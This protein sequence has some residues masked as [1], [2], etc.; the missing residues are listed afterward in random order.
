SAQ[1][2]QDAAQG[3]LRTGM[4][5][6]FAGTPEFAL[7]TLDAIAASAHQLVGVL[8]QPD[9]PAGRGRKLKASPVK[10]RALEWH[11]PVQQPPSLKDDAAFVALAAWAPDVIV[12]VAYGL[13]L[14]RQVLELPRYGCI[15]LHPS[16]LPRWRGAAPIQRALLA[17]DDATGVSIM[18]LDAGLDSGPVYV[19]KK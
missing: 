12:I 9:R 1:A 15:N 13:L 17:G 10:R 11:V 16:L 14:P 7:P 4:K 8:T 3:G 5:I 2:G 19:K 18:Q 6:V